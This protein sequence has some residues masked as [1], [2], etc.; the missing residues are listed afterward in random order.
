[1]MDGTII[2]ITVPLAYI[3]VMLLTAR[4]RYRVMRP[5]TEP[6]GCKTPSLCRS[7]WHTSSCYRRW[8]LVD[9]AGEA[10]G[11][12]LLTGLVW[13]LI[14]PAL[15]VRHL[16]TAGDRPLPAETEAKIKRL[17]AENDR[18]RRQQEGVS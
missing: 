17:E 10:A 3:T 8:G 14:G 2:A 5:Y 7:T 4:W 16:V 13:P 6:L 11:F 9:S 15:V 1:M 18:L 12:A